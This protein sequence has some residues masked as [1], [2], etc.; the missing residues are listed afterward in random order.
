VI[1]SYL[2]THDLCCPV[3]DAFDA[4]KSSTMASGRVLG[5]ENRDFLG[6][7]K[8]YRAHHSARGGLKGGGGNGG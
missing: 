5:S 2:W 6:P 8:W 7:V 3:L 1:I 4:G